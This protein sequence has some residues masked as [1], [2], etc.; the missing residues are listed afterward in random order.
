LLLTV[1]ALA[2]AAPLLAH[3]ALRVSSPAKDEVLTA[4]PTQL[5]LTFNERIE[6]TLARLRLLTS[7]STEIPVGPLR[8]GDSAQV[9][10]APINTRLANGTYA[11]AW[12]VMGVDGHPVR[13]RYS[14]VV[15]APPAPADTAAAL[16]VT[17]GQEGR[18]PTPV[19]EET[20][21]GASVNAPAYVA[22]RWLTFAALIVAI[23]AVG[24]R[25]LVLGSF[26]KSAPPAARA[27]L[28][29]AAARAALIGRGSLI[30][31]VLAAGVRLL[32]QVSAV[33]MPGANG[34]VV[35]NLMFGTT[36]GWGWIVQVVAAAA[37]AVAFHFAMRSPHSGWPI[38]ATF[39][40]ILAFTPALSGH[41][42]A[43]ERL[44]GVAILTDGVHVIAVAGWLGTLLLMI[45][46]GFSEALRADSASAPA[47]IARMVNAF[48]PAALA[49]AGVAAATGIA[50][51]VFQLGSLQ[52][53][54]AT[55]Y[56]RTLL[57]KLGAVALVVGAGAFNWRRMKPRLTTGLD[58]ERLR[59]S[60]KL[61]LAAAALVLLVTAVL[62]AVPTP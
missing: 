62:V 21:E 33:A 24:F 52:A 6:V 55:T 56:G 60:A 15:S 11:V 12:Q 27:M 13:G 25:Y 28:E 50:S 44:T 34:A 7:D 51:A 20:A 53:L 47:A 59:T 49:F 9:I 39:A 48:S 26:M 40:V 42:A 41:A 8:S 57:I 10:V 17:P 30:F 18:E 19:P 43:V 1:V 4:S 58:A 45:G 35:Q 46:V 31:L 37:G 22:V 16:P 2:I 3:T 32:L 54:W 23:G 5:V 36:W 61:E 38:A 29:P 14:F